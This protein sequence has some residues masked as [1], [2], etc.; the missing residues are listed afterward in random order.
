[1][2][3]FYQQDIDQNTRLAVWKIEEEESFFLSK[4]PLQ[5]DISHQH[6]RLQHLAGRYLLKY[7]FPEFPLELIRIAD[8][9]RPFLEG[10]PYHFSISH[11]GSFA[12][13][14]VSRNNR[15]GVDIEI[16]DAKVARI[17]HKFL[18]PQEIGELDMLKHEL[19]VTGKKDNTYESYAVELRALTLFWSSKEA[20][21]K[22][23]SFGKVDFRK[24]I[25]LNKVSEGSAGAIEANFISESPIP[26]KVHYILF[27]QVCL[28]WVV[29][30]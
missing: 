7:L 2:P 21:F 9:L 16:P 10:D 27:E 20:I 19:I 25:R 4:V 6:K 28:A 14:I 18:D 15:V 3:I 23:W 26:L 30:E 17:K 8:T 22:W 1:M 24:N 12:A 29:T 5:R 13:V 11:C